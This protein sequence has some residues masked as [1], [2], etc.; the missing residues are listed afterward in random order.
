MVHPKNICIVDL[1]SPQHDI[2]A[3]EGGHYRA[4]IM[5]TTM[6]VLGTLLLDG[7]NH[8]REQNHPQTEACIISSVCTPNLFLKAI[9]VSCFH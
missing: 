7:I 8:K 3:Q 6:M 1:S 9:I 5:A 2:I 4:L